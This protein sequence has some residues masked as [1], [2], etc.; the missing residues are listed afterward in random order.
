MSSEQLRKIFGGL[1]ST[2]EHSWMGLVLKD[3]PLNCSKYK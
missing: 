3:I 1:G 2:N